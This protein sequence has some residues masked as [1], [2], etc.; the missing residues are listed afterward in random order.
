[1]KPFRFYGNKNKNTTPSTLC[2][3]LDLAKNDAV[4]RKNEDDQIKITVLPPTNATGNITN[5]D[6]GNEG[7]LGTINNLPESM[8]LSSIELNHKRSTT[9]EDDNEPAK[10][11]PK[12]KAKKTKRK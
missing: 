3:I 8:L 4:S 1:M 10:K 6:S 11:K 12:K 2:R 9:T 5:E 7:G